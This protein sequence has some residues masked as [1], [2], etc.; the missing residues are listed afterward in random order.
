MVLREGTSKWVAAGSIAG[1]FP[2]AAPAPTAETLDDPQQT[3]S[4]QAGTPRLPEGR[5][6]SPT[7]VNLPGYEILSE[8][9]RGGMGVVY[10]ARQTGLGRLVAL[11]MILAGPHAGEQHLARFRTEAQAAA[12]L[13][14]P[15]IV[16][17]YEIGEHDGLP[18]LSLEYVEGGSLA[19]K[20]RGTPRPAREAAAL[21]ETLAR[22]VQAAHDKGIVHRDLKPANVL[23]T[24]ADVPKVAD[25]GL[26]K[27]VEGEA[28]GV[29][30]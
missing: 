4:Y 7:A 15:N 19:G 20:L 13:Q 22:A 21:V 17:I 12:R 8:L 26:A 5:V 2:P 11:K 16:Q 27:L 6:S 9:G 10:Q 23:L 1:L 18:F 28:A 25:F 30:R 29:G 24:T 3:G 14:H